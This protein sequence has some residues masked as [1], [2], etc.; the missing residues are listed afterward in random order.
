MWNCRRVA[1]SYLDHWHE[2]R[3]RRHFDACVQL[4][5]GQRKPAIRPVGSSWARSVRDLVRKA[6][7]R[8]LEDSGC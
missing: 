8:R 3:T 4:L 6:D 1:P 7:G 2:Y 5:P